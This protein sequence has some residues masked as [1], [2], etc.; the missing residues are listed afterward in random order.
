MNKDTMN[1]R[2]SFVKL[3]KGWHPSYF[4]AMLLFALYCAFDFSPTNDVAIW[5]Q[6][7]ISILTPLFWQLV[8]GGCL[9]AIV[10]TKPGAKWTT[11]LTIPGLALGGIVIWYCLAHNI[12]LVILVFV[13]VAY[14]AVVGVTVLSAFVMKS[15]EDNGRLISRVAELEQQIVDTTKAANASQRESN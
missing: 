3:L 8:L 11:Y 13:L 6:Q 7:K 10:L 2:D 15:L 5:L 12:P 14:P 9:A 1:T 4:N